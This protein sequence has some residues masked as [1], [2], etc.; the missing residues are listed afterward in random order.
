[1]ASIANSQTSLWNDNPSEVDLLGFDAVVA[2]I[3][4]AIGTE[5]LDPITN[6]CAC[7]LEWREIDC[8]RISSSIPSR[9]REAATKA[10]VQA[11]PA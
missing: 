4:D 8:D 10:F 5:D 9:N 2:P 3:V 1:M 6:W 7:P 11:A